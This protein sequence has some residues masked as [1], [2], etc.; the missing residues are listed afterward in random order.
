MSACPV[1]GA[2]LDGRRADAVYCSNGCRQ[3]AY[4]FRRL[5]AG[6]PVGR[7]V[8]VSDRMAAF[9]RPRRPT[10]NTNAVEGSRMGDDNRN[11]AA[12]R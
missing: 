8:S 2:S 9:G 10:R 4:R 6:R 1:C 12:P 3:E 11:G 5:L 7:Y